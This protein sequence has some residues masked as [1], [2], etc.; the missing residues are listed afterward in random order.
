MRVS[1][2][3]TKQAGL[4]KI[5]KIERISPVSMNFNGTRDFYLPE[6]NENLN[7]IY[8]MNS[9]H[10]SAGKTIEIPA[11]NKS[12]SYGGQKSGLGYF[13]DLKI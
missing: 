12:H 2:S 7:Q 3:K 11:K 5:Q 13:I 6:R 4:T 10:L 9:R 1:H 8:F